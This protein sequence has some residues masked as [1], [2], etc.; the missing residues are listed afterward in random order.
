MRWGSQADQ[1][2]Q[3]HEDDVRSHNSILVQIGAFV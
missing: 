1:R 2:G 3:G